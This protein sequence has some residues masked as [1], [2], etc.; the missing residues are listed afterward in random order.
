MCSP[1]DGRGITIQMIA[2]AMPASVNWSK[3]YG[4]IP[5][6]TMFAA[7]GRDVIDLGDLFN[8]TAGTEHVASIARP[9]DSDAISRERVLE[10]LADSPDPDYIDAASLARTLNRLAAEEAPPPAA[11]GSILGEAAF[12]IFLA[13]DGP[14]PAGNSTCVDRKA[15]KAFKDRAEVFLVEER[16]PFELGW[17]PSRREVQFADLAPMVEVIVAAQA[18]DQSE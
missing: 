13:L 7:L 1:H 3:D 15:L 12:T 10:A 16:F 4:L 5:G 2:D 9:N 11:A 14:I 6:Q 17:K 18:A 8:R